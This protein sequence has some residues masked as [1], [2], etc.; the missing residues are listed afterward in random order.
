MEALFSSDICGS[1]KVLT[2]IFLCR[3]W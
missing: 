2:S 3:I 1:T